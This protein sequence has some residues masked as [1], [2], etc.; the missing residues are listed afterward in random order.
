MSFYD[1]SMYN[2]EDCIHGTEVEGVYGKFTENKGKNK[3]YG[4]QHEVINIKNIKEVNLKLSKANKT[5]KLT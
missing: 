5:Y 3:K 2:N 4:T 1:P